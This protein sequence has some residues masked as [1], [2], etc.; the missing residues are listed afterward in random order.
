M[1][2]EGGSC[3]SLRREVAISDDLRHSDHLVCMRCDEISV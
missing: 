2:G 1:G 3:P